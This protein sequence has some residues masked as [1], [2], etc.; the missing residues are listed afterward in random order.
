M[1]PLP[2]AYR[3][4]LVTGA[5]RGI[6][7][8]ICRRLVALGLQVHAVA[9][10]AKALAQLQG[11]LGD[12]ADG[13][14]GLVVH[15]GDV[16]DLPAMAR[17]CAA[18]EIDVL[19]NNAGQVAALGS[20][21][22]LDAQA[23]DRMIDVNLRAPLQLMRLLLPGMLARG[24]GHIIN[25]GSTAGGFVFP[26]TAPYAASKAG[27]T[28]AGRVLR[29]DLVGRNIRVTE[30]SPGRVH[31]DIYREAFG[32]REQDWSALYAQRRTVQPED[33]AHCVAVAL[34]L[35]EAVDVSF[36]EVSPTDQAPG[37][38]AYAAPP[39]AS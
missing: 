35:P 29:H 13:A 20:L 7:A 30:I 18:R 10:D 17:L 38:H 25:I 16:T 31:T 6:G 4:A 5:S 28:A 27:M 36:M 3:H 33:I 39:S 32:A 11:E 15:R 14:A 24:H 34:C 9:R 12:A 8:A 2:A 19:V 23:I 37:G 22:T 1:L 21:E 26:G